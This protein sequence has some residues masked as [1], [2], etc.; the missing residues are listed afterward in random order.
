M[1]ERSVVTKRI[2]LERA[3]NGPP[4]PE[5]EV[6]EVI[7]KYQFGLQ[8]QMGL[9]KGFISRYET[10][11]QEQVD[12]INAGMNCIKWVREEAKSEEEEISF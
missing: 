10:M 11:T 7:A 3:E 5:P 1:T 12:K 4:T 6:K 9:N 8:E 2:K